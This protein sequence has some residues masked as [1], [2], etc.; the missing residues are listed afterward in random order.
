[1]RRLT[2]L[3]GVA[4]ALA[5]GTGCFEVKLGVSL[6]PDGSVGVTESM[7]LTQG[8]IDLLWDIGHEDRAAG[9]RFEAAHQQM[10]SRFAAPT[11]EALDAMHAAGVRSLDRRVGAD[12]K[13]WGME[14]SAVYD[15]IDA[16]KTGWKAAHGSDGIPSDFVQLAV[17]C[18]P[19][20]VCTLDYAQPPGEPGQNMGGTPFDGLADAFKP[21]EED[22][23]H[24]PSKREEKATMERVSHMMEVMST[25]AAK[26]KI[27][28]TLTLPGEVLEPLP[29]GTTLSGQ[30]LS[31]G[32]DGAAMVAAAMGGAQGAPPAPDMLPAGQVRFR[33]PDGAPIPA[34]WLAAP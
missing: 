28:A 21:E 10:V 22:P 32:T 30:T 33:L 4:C 9:A 8:V 17:S 34:D 23:K 29:Q 5:L 14:Q 11:G 7:W 1:M 3:V 6:Q 15:S 20:R 27:A 25:E 31:W 2:G 16:L 19:D 12:H 18:T 26:L 13:Q 24:K